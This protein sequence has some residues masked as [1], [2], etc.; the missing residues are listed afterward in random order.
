VQ[1]LHGES[2]QM[3]EIFHSGTAQPL[4]LKKKSK[5]ILATLGFATQ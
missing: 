1:E 5:K 2:Y 3:E 4:K